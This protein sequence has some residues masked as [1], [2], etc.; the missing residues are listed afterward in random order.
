M[1]TIIIV[2][3]NSLC[4]SIGICIYM[5]VVV[6]SAETARANLPEQMDGAIEAHLIPSSCS[7]GRHDPPKIRNAWPVKPAFAKDWRT[8]AAPLGLQIAQSRS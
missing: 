3:M 8:G 4:M 6:Y 7:Y 1:I 5:Y 2:I